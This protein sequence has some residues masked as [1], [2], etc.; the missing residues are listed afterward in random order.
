MSNSSVLYRQKGAHPKLFVGAEDIYLIDEKGNKIIDG[1]SNSMNVNL[2]YS[3]NRIVDAMTKQANTLPFMHNKKGTTMV[4]EELAWKLSSL[5][6][7]EYRC[8]FCSNGSDAIETALRI[9]YQYHVSKN[10][11]E[12]K[13]FLSWTESYHGSSMAALSVTGNDLVTKPYENFVKNYAKLKFP[14]CSNC[15]QTDCKFECMAALDEEQIR[16]SAGIVL[17]G[18]LTNCFGSKLPG[19]S[20]MEKIQEICRDNDIAIIVDEIATS[21]GRTGKHYAFQ[22]YDGFK[23]DIICLS[24]GIGVGYANLG[25]VLVSNHFLQSI[26]NDKDFLGHT[27]NGQPISCSVGITA[28]EILE[29]DHILENVREREKELRGYLQEILKIPGVM[30]FSG[31]GLMY[32]IRFDRNIVGEDFIDRFNQLSIENELLLLSA[33]L[34]NS[35][36]ITLSPPLIITKEQLTQLCTRLEGIIRKCIQ[37]R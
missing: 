12:R 4:Q 16:T 18:M 7:N 3:Q 33:K 13:N 15:H 35:M 23:P 36:H 37:E 10:H 26:D 11:K 1:C 24:K 9:T 14:D 34:K 31:K 32:S 25:A 29:T 17:D 8:Y 22:H 21:I 20:Y 2:G 28:L 30:D 27:Y 6:N 5:L 19:H